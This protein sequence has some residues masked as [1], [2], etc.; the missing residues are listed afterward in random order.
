[1]AEKNKKECLEYL[2]QMRSPIEEMMANQAALS[3]EDQAFIAKLKGEN[4]GEVV[5]GTATAY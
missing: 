1:M 5:D 3:P 4:Q 2:K